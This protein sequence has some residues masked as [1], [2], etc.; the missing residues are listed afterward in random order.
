VTPGDFI[1]NR[2]RVLYR[3]GEGGMGEVWAAHDELIDQGVA[4]KVMGKQIAN[5]PD[6]RR[7]FLNEATSMSRLRHPNIVAALASG[8]LPDGFPYIALELLDGISIETHLDEVRRLAAEEAALIGIQ[9]CRGLAQAHRAGVIHR[10]LNPSNVF[11][12]RYSDETV[13]VKILDF[14]ISK[15]NFPEHAALVVTA[16]GVALG[17]ARYMSHEQARGIADIDG[18]TDIWS[19][20]V[21]LYEAVSGALPFNGPNYNAVLAQIVGADPPP[22][23]AELGLPPSLVAIIAR[24]LAKARGQRFQSAEELEKALDTVIS[25]LPGRTS[26][27]APRRKLQ[28]LPDIDCPP[29]R[30]HRSS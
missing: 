1:A 30:S 3:I 22:L 17:T 15:S 27:I 23:P 8:E 4:I 6:A 2:Y 12:C 29:A 16:A 7:R 9:I 21:I 10:D 25:G 14:G 19:L 13:N 26:G 18:R 5:W 28:S 20:G 24:C 11:L